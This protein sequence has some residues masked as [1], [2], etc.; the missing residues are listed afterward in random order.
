M[1]DED[2]VTFPQAVRI[3][4]GNDFAHTTGA[5]E[6]SQDFAILEMT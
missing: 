2:T 6:G 1:N 4:N 3:P 5:R